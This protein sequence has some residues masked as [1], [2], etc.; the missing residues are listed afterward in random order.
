MFCVIFS[1]FSFSRKSYS[2]DFGTITFAFFSKSSFTIREPRNPE[3]PVTRTFL[4]LQSILK[5]IRIKEI[6]QLI[7][8]EILKSFLGRLEV[9]I[10]E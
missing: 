1:Q 8:F 6:N 2:S 7:Y 3:P 10:H 4:S 9:K 5:I